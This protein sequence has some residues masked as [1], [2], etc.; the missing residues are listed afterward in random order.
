MKLIPVNPTELTAKY[1][2]DK[3]FIEMNELDNFH[4]HQFGFVVAKVDNETKEIQDNFIKNDDDNTLV[5]KLL[6]D[7]NIKLVEQSISQ[8]NTAKNDLVQRT[9]YFMPFIPENHCSLQP[10]ATDDFISGACNAHYEGKIEI[11]LSLDEGLKRY[12]IMPFSTRNIGMLDMVHSAFDDKDEL[13][14]AFANTDTP[15]VWQD[16]TDDRN[17]GFLLDFYNARGELYED[18]FTLNDLQLAI[19]S[20]RMLEL[21]C[22]I[23]D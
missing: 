16:E 1:G 10:T 5:T 6:A 8:F 14:E 18:T 2:F 3:T 23:D 22:I 4:G 12:L 11:L 13:Q 9:L 21:N 19:S 7:K 20:I 17:A 15:F